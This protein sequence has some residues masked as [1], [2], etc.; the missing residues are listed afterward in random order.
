M[1][2]P[3]VFDASVVLAFAK[4]EPGADALQELRP[5]ALLSAVNAA[6]VYAKLLADG[7]T[8]AQVTDGLRVVARRV[9]AFDDDQC[10]LAGALH[11]ATRLHGLSLADCAC[12]AL[13]RLSSATVYTADRAWAALDVGVAVK[14]IR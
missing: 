10:R 4:R 3:V 6:E 8:D 11:A 1:T 13:G 5:R 7:L 14:L 12:L 9:V 2:E